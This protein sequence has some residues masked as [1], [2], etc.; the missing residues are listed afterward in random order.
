V[1]AIGVSAPYRA[2]GKRKKWGH[3]LRLGAALVCLALASCNEPAAP[4]NQASVEPPVVP[5]SR[6]FV[7]EVADWDEFT[8]RFSAV[9]EVQVRARASGFLTQ[10]HFRDG[11]IVQE[12]D[13]L[14]TIDPR[15][16]ETAVQAAEAS[17]AEAEASL[18][19]ARTELDRAQQLQRT[20]ALPEAVYDQRK[21]TVRRAEAQMLLSQANLRRARLELEYTEVRAPFAGRA[22]RHYVSV[23]HLVTSDTTVLTHL[24]SIDPIHLLFDIDQNAFLRYIRTAQGSAQDDLTAAHGRI[25]VQLADEAG[26]PHEGRVDFVSNRA[27]QDTGTVRARGI[28]RNERQV[29]LPGMFGRAR[30]RASHSYEAVLLP[31]TAIGTDQS[32]RFI[33]VVDAHGTPRRQNVELGRLIDGLR[34][35]RSGVTPD[36]MV[37]VG[38]LQRVR[39][40]QRVMPRPEP[41]VPPLT[42]AQQDATGASGQVA[43]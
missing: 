17:V 14:F 39:P 30:M 29:F 43:R 7:R 26:F 9:A 13:R 37:V 15:P 42:A 19:V 4:Q 3:G 24:V 25:V 18:A 33:Y 10:I 36:D 23:G 38:G 21:A 40:G 27:D 32:R 31:D 1:V 6:P 22:D 41:I 12:G 5:V 11:H 2:S 28:L 20:Q 16:Y 35:L 8:G 34:V